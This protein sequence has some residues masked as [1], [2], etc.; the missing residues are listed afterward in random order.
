MV[1]TKRPAR[2]SKEPGPRRSSARLPILS[3]NSSAARSVKVKA[4]I[5]S[6]GKPSAN[7]SA[8]RCETTSVLPEPAP[9]II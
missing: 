1:P 8:T 5:A 6:G 4:T 2:R 3:F 9:A 7:R